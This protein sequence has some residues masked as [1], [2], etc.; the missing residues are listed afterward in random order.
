M[1]IAIIQPACF[2]DNINSTVMLIPIKTKWPDAH[3]T[4]HTTDLYQ[5]AFKNNPYINETILY[6]A[7]NKNGALDYIYKIHKQLT[8]YDIIFNPHPMGNPDKWTTTK[9]DVG[10][11]IISAWL[12]ALEDKDIPYSRPLKT[13]LNL[14]PEEN[15][16]VSTYISTIKEFTNKPKVLIETGAESGQSQFNNDWMKQISKYFIDKGYNIFISRK[17]K[18]QDIVKLEK[19]SNLV[20]FVGELSLRETAGLYNHMDVFISTG[21]GLSCA[22]NTQNMKTTVKWFEVVNSTSIDTSPIRTENKKFWYDNNIDGF[23]NMINQTI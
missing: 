2:G 9:S 11:N 7:T 20:H 21:S 3:I 16:K 22:C 1:K 8:G 14:T 6:P 10:T 12:R 15:I 13:I 18:D 4:M 23:I 17:N 5:S 19:Q